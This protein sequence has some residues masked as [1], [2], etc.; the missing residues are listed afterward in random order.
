MTTYRLKGASGKVANQSFGLG[1]K[2]VIGSSPDCDL[3][4]NEEKVAPKHAEIRLAAN[5]ELHLKQLHKS[6][7]IL[8]NGNPVELAS[9]ASGDEIRIGSCRWVL[10]A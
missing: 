8:L 4:V 7:N 3:I 6:F 2:T 5:G 1:D 10:Q 9:L